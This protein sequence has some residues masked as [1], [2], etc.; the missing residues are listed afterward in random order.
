MGSDW[1][2]HQDRDNRFREAIARAKQAEAQ[3][4][5]AK[6]E[7]ASN[8]L[9]IDQLAHERNG[10][11]AEREAMREALEIIAGKRQCLDN[12]MSNVEVARAAIRRIYAED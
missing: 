5:E 4:A 12:L 2:M 10:A 1:V 6:A 7:L 3:L 11:E 9:V 8:K